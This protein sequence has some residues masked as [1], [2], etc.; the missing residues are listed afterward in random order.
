ML[1]LQHALQHTLLAASF[2]LA[3]QVRASWGRLDRP[4][5]IIGCGRSGTT[6]L[7]ET[8]SKHPALVYL[9]E[10][11]P[12]WVNDPRT[13]VWSPAAR[14]RG[15]RLRLAADDAHPDAQRTLQ[16]AFAFA[17]FGQPGSRMV[18]K[19][20]INS[21]RV[22][23][24]DRLFPDAL[25]IH[26]VRNGVEVA[27]SIAKETQKY[28]WFGHEDYKWNLL[29]AEASGRG[30]GDLAALCDG[31]NALRGLLEWRL[32]VTQAL[33]SLGTLPEARWMQ[34]RYEA[35]TQDPEPVCARLQDFIGVPVDAGVQDSARGH[36]ARRTS[37]ADMAV[38]PPTMRRIGGELLQ[39]LGYL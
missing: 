2:K 18:E 19:L 27:Q 15:G 29:A 20:P 5:F 11:R 33:E 16:Q 37:P 24:I 7:G 23:Y 26:L 22:G 6:I 17:L 8:L 35:L 38:L 30:L 28:D 4:V 9:N 3:K 32:S 1:K 10:P 21:F 12:L 13:D 36:I 34:V 25:F 31:D 39:Q 14:E